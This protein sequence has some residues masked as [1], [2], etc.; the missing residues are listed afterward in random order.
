ME[1]N[2]GLD[3]DTGEMSTGSNDDIKYVVIK[4]NQPQ[5]QP[6]N[7]AKLVLMGAQEPSETVCKTSALSEASINLAEM[8]EG[9]YLCYSTGQGLHGYLRATLS[10]LAENILTL[11]YRTWA[12]P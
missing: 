10:S 12:N 11:E 6:V 4:E 5:I 8:K 7:G 3:L 2:A 1:V 9:S